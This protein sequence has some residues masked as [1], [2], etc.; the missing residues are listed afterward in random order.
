VA[1]RR[2]ADGQGVAKRDKDI[3]QAALL[4]EALLLTSDLALVYN[5]AW[6]C[7]PTGIFF[8]IVL[9]PARYGTVKTSPCRSK[10][11]IAVSW[12]LVIRILQSQFLNNRIEQDH[13][14]I[15]QRVRSML[16]FKS[17]RGAALTLAGIEMV[18]MMRKRQGCFAFNPA[19]TLKEQ[20]EAI[21]A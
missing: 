11:K 3:R 17:F 7:G 18:H 5:E 4:Y 10:S 8:G 16:G 13:R 6:E 21:A 14:R 12:N 15:K 20:F 1:S 19:P 9:L 2:Q